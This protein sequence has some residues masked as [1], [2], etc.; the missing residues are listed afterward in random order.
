MQIHRFNDKVAIY[1]G[2]GKEIYLT[3]DQARLISEAIDSCAVDIER[4]KF[5]ESTFRT[6]SFDFKGGR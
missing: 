6:Q 4:K 3:S 1:L 5:T 2:T